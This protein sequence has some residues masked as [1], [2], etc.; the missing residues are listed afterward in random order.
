MKCCSLYEEESRSLSGSELDLTELE[1]E[2]DVYG[3]SDCFDES[4]FHPAQVARQ[5]AITDRSISV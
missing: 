3:D 2:D 4:V 5:S 1:L